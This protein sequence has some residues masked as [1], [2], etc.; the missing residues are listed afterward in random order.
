MSPAPPTPQHPDAGRASAVNFLLLLLQLLLL[1]VV[2]V[3]VVASQGWHQ[4]LQLRVRHFCNP[5]GT[6]T[7]VAYLA[8]NQ[9]V[10]SGIFALI[11]LARLTLLGSLNLNTT[12]IW[13]GIACCCELFLVV[14][15]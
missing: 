4:V 3:V 13:S 5:L 11:F 6:Q 9:G 2:V 15:T 14:S 12:T 8:H 1:V 7:G 10:A